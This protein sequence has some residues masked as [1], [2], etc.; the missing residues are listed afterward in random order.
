MGRKYYSGREGVGAYDI[1]SDMDIGIPYKVYLGSTV[2]E[3][4]TT[5]ENVLP[6]LQPENQVYPYI[7]LHIR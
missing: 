1:W 3:V 6:H 2:I 7:L 5:L 4:Y